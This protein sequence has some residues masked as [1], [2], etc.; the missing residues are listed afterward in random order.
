MS[1]VRRIKSRLLRL[2]GLAAAPGGISDTVQYVSLDS[3][4]VSRMHAI[5]SLDGVHL[6]SRPT[7]YMLAQ[8][9]GALA[10]AAGTVIDLNTV[11]GSSGISVASGR[12]S[13]SAGG[14]YYA[15]CSIDVSG[16]AP[17]T[18]P[19]QWIED[20]AGAATAVGSS[21]KAI[22]VPS[23]I[24]ESQQPN[25]SAVFVP[26][27]GGVDVECQMIA[28]G[29]GGIVNRGSSFILILQVA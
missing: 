27:T 3:G 1:I 24:S 9:S 16:A 29:T 26:P 8:G 4:G 17:T 18:I 11:L 20:P 19:F 12:F 25:A 2:T 6:I 13:L 14:V 21:G 23:A 5:D 15:T 22:V 10:Y 28:G 7:N